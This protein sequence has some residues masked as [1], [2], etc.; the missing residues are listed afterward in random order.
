MIDTDAFVRSSPYKLSHGETSDKFNLTNTTSDLLKFQ[1]QEQYRTTLNDLKTNDANTTINST[2]DGE[3]SFAHSQVLQDSF[4]NVLQTQIEA[5]E[6]HLSNST[7]N[8]SSASTT[9]STCVG[10]YSN[11]PL[12]G[13]VGDDNEED[14][15]RDNLDSFISTKS[16]KPNYLNLK[17]LIENSIFDSTRIKSSILDFYALNEL[18]AAIENK[19]ELQNYL[20]SKI[21]TAQSF[22]KMI[23]L[24]SNVDSNLLIKIIK[25]QSSLQS[26]LIEISTE[27]EKL[28]EKLSN[29]YFSCLS[30]GYI[31]DI[32]VSRNL[33]STSTIQQSPLNSPGKI[34]SN[35]SSP[36]FSLQLQQNFDSLIA[37]I[38][39][40]A[41]QRNISLPHPPY[42]ETPGSKISWIQSCIDSI[43]SNT[44][45]G[46]DGD[47]LHDE[48]VSTTKKNL[49]VDFIKSNST[50]P[51]RSLGP[52]KVVYEYKTALNDLRFSYEYLSKEYEMSKISSDKMIHDYRKKI[53]DLQKKLQSTAEL[54]TPP[55]TTSMGSD[56]DSLEN[57]DK[58]ITRLR[59]ELNL[60]KIEKIGK[61][62]NS[63]HNVSM[64]SF[65]SS[66]NLE[67]NHSAVISP[68]TGESLNIPDSTTL[69]DGDDDNASVN[70][71]GRPSSSGYSN[72]ILRKEFRK[73]VSDIQDQ[74]E[75][76]L[77]EE[78]VRR[79]KLEEELEKENKVLR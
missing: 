11:N 75:M 14:E 48:L 78:R 3:S 34:P 19:Q 26:Q 76:E 24:E 30:L 65:V 10:D 77:A 23:V 15:D 43:L 33:Q 16:N 70:S 79:R 57:K 55:R 1:L 4:N 36:Q 17:I 74:Y 28:K 66:P 61:P 62:Y 39:S 69:V 45:P 32:R 8:L 64:T 46:Q 12:G 7:G 27:L 31:E 2:V 71:H 40:V 20:L 29:H 44:K 59:K 21:S 56:S 63:N 50:S 41:A 22:N 60:L 58:E 67:F 25:T 35:S 47:N 54:M 49:S 5:G 52:D 53:N 37:H 18:K 73:I 42:T 6:I 51:L 38:A 13:G 72:G 68:I 9:T